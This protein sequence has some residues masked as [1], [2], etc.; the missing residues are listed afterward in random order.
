MK[1]KVRL[2]IWIFFIG[3]TLQSQEPV[4]I[5]LT[6]KDGLPDI[7]FYD[8]LEDKK[9]F[10]WLAAD[11][12]L[13]RY[14]GRDFLQYTNSEK[15][16]LSV[17]G[18]NEDDEGRI[19]CVNISGQIFYSEGNKLKTFIDLRSELKG[20]L[21]N[22]KVV[23]NHL[24]V[25]GKKNIY[26]INITTKQIKLQYNNGLDTGPV[27]EPSRYG[28]NY[29]FV[30][31]KKIIS[32]DKTFQ[33]RVISDISDLYNTTRGQKF[34]LDN[35]PQVLIFNKDTLL[36]HKLINGHAIF[37]LKD[38]AIVKKAM[39]GFEILT[40][41]SVL[42][43][44]VHKN[45]LIFC[46]N[47]GVYFFEKSK[48][49]RFVKSFLTSETISDVIVDKDDNY[50]FTSLRNG[51]YV[52]TNIHVS[53]F[54]NGKNSKNLSALEKLGND[55]I[56]FG[57]TNGK[58]GVYNFSNNSLQLTKLL[59][60]ANVSSIKVNPYRDILYVSQ[61][62]I[63]QVINLKTNEILTTKGFANAKDIELQN[64]DDILITSYFG[65]GLVENAHKP[66]TLENRKIISSNRGYSSYKSKN[67]K[68][69]YV[70]H[71][72]DLTR[73]DQDFQPFPIRFKNQ[74]IFA[75]SITEDDE[76]AIW[77]STF[78]NGIYKIFNGIAVD[79]YTTDDG[80]LSNQVSEVFSDGD[81]LW[82]VS[83]N[84]I[85]AFNTKSKTFKSLD[86][87]DGIP[88]FKIKGIEKIGEQIIFA[89]NSGLFGIHRSKV[90]KTVR[91]PHIYFSNVKIQDRDT[92]IKNLYTLPYDKNNLSFT[93]NTN[94]FQE[95]QNSIFEYKLNSNKNWKLLNEGENTIS[96][97][98]LES[99]NYELQVRPKNFG[100][101]TFPNAASIAFTIESPFWKRWWF[102][103]LCILVTVITAGLVFQQLLLK[104][105]RKQE[106]K[107]ELANLQNDL[108]HLEL[109]NLRSQMNPHFIFNA[110][111]SIQ[112]YIILNQKDLASD[113]LGKFSDLIRGYL[114]NS[115]QDRILLI[116]EINGL[117]TYLE[118]ERMRFEEDF[119]YRFSFD[120]QSR[121]NDYEI[122]TMLLQ[123]YIEN[124]L[125][126]GL[127]HKRGEKILI[128]SGNIINYRTDREALQVSIEDNGV[129]RNY[130]K[131]AHYNSKR[132]KPFA[133]RATEK[134]LQLMRKR[135][136]ALI[137]VSYKDLMDSEG[138]AIGTCVV[139]TIP[140]V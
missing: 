2:F 85:Q 67:G 139:I 89:S 113:Y 87:R 83:N 9:G 25:F 100:Y 51:V 13:F 78:K 79:N 15:R 19:W 72:D 110:L 20:N 76:G 30:G 120:R 70:S 43:F 130:K 27:G 10:I 123:P 63:A 17:F 136:A 7:E 34:Q 24:L 28:E 14:D 91:P 54:H 16:G 4:S 29:L 114:D 103:S 94:S 60:E 131:S 3:L 44:V 6:E 57:T 75:I 66:S 18:L 135:T 125:K 77:V 102:L 65:T 95:D 119:S 126:H 49:Y 107:L 112:E 56:V 88:S 26:S 90:F 38:G 35:V 23:N 117:E 32:L 105:E 122:P 41:L 50:W 68:D 12:G 82:L 111:N 69:F 47:K 21:P 48:D 140:L 8:V 124:A 62:N 108:V 137:G 37:K 96:F 36:S 116:D 33:Q 127:L 134:R 133:T 128:I 64:K 86:K 93:V 22:I 121:E 97:N 109:E 61:D 104:K 118:L 80:L 42:K 39:K 58:M 5:H 55:Q 59:T 71:V 81:N 101:V 53:I 99:G 45:H 52:I 115:S 73:Y 132:H 106:E 46:T 31:D 92:I 84:A 11:R 129:G 1:I 40:G 98:A 74:S 138:N